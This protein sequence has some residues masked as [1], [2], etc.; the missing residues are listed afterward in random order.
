MLAS[1]EFYTEEVSGGWKEAFRNPSLRVVVPYRS[2][3]VE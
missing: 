3:E 2:F 1:Q